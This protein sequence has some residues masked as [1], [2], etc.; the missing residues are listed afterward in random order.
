MNAIEM[1]ISDALTVDRICDSSGIAAAA[2]QAELKRKN[3]WKD[4]NGR[5]LGRKL[6]RL[7]SQY[8][9]KISTRTLNGKALYIVTRP[10]D[11]TDEE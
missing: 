11:V 8:P 6:S 7:C 10:A 1:L 4:E 9:N 3:L 2:L 5:S